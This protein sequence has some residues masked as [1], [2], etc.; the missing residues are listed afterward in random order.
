M[1]F[2]FVFSCNFY[3]SVF[4]SNLWHYLAFEFHIFPPKKSIAIDQYIPGLPCIALILQTAAFQFEKLRC[5]FLFFL[6]QTHPRSNV[7][8]FKQAVICSCPVGFDVLRCNDKKK[9]VLQLYKLE[10][11]CPSPSLMSQ[12]NI[13]QQT[14]YKLTVE[15]Y[16][17]CFLF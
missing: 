8:L 5:Y 10:P 17:C 3:V 7:K 15:H 12:Y 6:H 13:L 9:D 14:K 1:F 4:I 16:V 11:A 2:C